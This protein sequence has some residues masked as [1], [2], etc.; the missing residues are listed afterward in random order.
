M[1]SPYWVEGQ[2][3]RP[4]IRRREALYDVGCF[5]LSSFYGGFGG[6]DSTPL[7]SRIR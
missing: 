6:S 7:E 3:D 1:N 5:C 2:K 4:H